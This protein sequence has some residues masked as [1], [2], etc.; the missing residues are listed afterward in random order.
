MRAFLV[1]CFG[2]LAVLLALCLLA[3]A[4]FFFKD[5]RSYF[6]ETHGHLTD[7][8]IVQAGGDSVFT[9]SWIT[10]SNETGLTVDCGWLTVPAAILLAWKVRRRDRT[11]A[12]S[13]IW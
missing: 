6:R 12:S 1:K 9:R 4:Y 5:Y 11:S 13:A 10:V 8:S 2:G 3:A 7:V